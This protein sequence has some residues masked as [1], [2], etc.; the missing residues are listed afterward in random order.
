MSARLEWLDRAAGAKA[1]PSSMSPRQAK[2][3]LGTRM[4]GEHQDLV[5]RKLI[6]KSDRSLVWIGC[7]TRSRVSAN[8][9][10]GVCRLLVGVERDHH[11]DQLHRGTLV[12]KKWTLMILSRTPHASAAESADRDGPGCRGDHVAWADQFLEFLDQCDLEVEDLRDRLDHDV[13]ARDVF[14]IRSEGDP[15]EHLSRRLV[16]L[17][18]FDRS[19]QRS[20]HPLPGRIRLRQIA[21]DDGHARDRGHLGDAAP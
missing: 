7:S 14:Q 17:A 20:L 10:R 12:K 2:L 8:A 21:D 1:M 5:S 13:R 4:G 3:F 18:A 15:G 11:P 6:M 9:N 16:N 19:G